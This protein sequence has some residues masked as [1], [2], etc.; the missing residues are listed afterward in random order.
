MQE[1]AHQ[2]AVLRIQTGCQGLGVALAGPQALD[3]LLEL[4]ALLL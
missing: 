3:R 2:R 4:P 1:L